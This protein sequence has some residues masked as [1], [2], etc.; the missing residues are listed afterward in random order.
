[1]GYDVRTGGIKT[2]H[3]DDTDDCF[4][5]RERASLS[6]IYDKA[7][8]KWGDDISLDDI[9]VEAEYIQMECIGYD[10]YAA[11][12]PV[13]YTNYLRVIKI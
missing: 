10:V 6:E 11:Y 5:I 2:F 3:P 8:E 1:M 13:D 7:K 4:Y 9:K 12:D